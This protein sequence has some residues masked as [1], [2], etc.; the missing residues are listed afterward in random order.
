MPKSRHYPPSYVKYQIEHPSVTVHLN[1]EVKQN[2][3]KVKRRRSYAQVISEI[4]EGT[5][6]LETEIKGLP[7]SEAVVQ[8][9]RGFKE[10]K[11]RYATFGVCLK[12]HKE[13]IL[14]NDGKC[15][16]CHKQGAGPDFS[17]FRDKESVMVVNDEDFEKAKIKL[18]PIEKLT[19]ENG[20]SR[21]YEEGW[22]DGFD[23]AIEDYRITYPCSVCGKPIEMM[24]GDNDHKAMIGYM[25]EKG[26]AHSKC[27]NG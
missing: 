24:P 11:S 7:V 2:L 19:Y 17:Y 10:A 12:C 23:E 25:K 20:R 8:Y 3:D 13:S 9:V 14:W 4:L 18:P 5:F 16:L 1:K 15:I 27:L 21:G 22:S 6:D 26:W